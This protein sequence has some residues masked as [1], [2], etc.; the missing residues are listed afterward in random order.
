MYDKRKIIQIIV[1]VLLVIA[2]IGTVMLFQWSAKRA[3]EEYN[4]QYRKLEEYNKQLN[5]QLNAAFSTIYE[6]N[7]QQEHIDGLVQS[8]GTIIGELRD[9]MEL[10][11][12]TIK[13]IREQQQRIRRAVEA[14]IADYERLRIALDGNTE[15]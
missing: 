7:K 14:L 8:S 4:E 9:S 6:L 1:Q 15:Y 2:C 10:H 13:A 12:D 3:N 5:D 11:G